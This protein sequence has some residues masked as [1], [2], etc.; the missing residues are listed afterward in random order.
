MDAVGGVVL[1]PAYAFQGIHEAGLAYL[2]L[3]HQDEFCLVENNLLVGLGA[4]ICL[5]SVVTF[6]MCRIK[7]QVK[8]LGILFQLLLDSHFRYSMHR[9]VSHCIPFSVISF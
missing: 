9:A 6:F 7:F 3:A 4:L 2:A 1:P 5:N 8:G